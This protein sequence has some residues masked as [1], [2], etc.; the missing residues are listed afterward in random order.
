MKESRLEKIKELIENNR[1]ETQEE[2]CRRLQDAGYEVTQATVSRDIRKL[3]L[4]KVSDK[5]GGRQY[6]ALIR[7]QSEDHLSKL[8]RVLRESYLNMDT[9]MNILV[10]RT[11][12]GMAM[13]CASAIDNLKFKEV[14]GCVAGD[15]TVLCAIR[16]VEDTQ[17]VMEKIKGLVE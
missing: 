8:I 1:I 15:D 4:T 13:A 12:S 3:Q 17:V 2:L 9:A 14:V 7:E 16:T 11:V 6:Y 10:I 5:K